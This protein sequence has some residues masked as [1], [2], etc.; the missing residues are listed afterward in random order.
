MNE[1]GMLSRNL[2]LGEL[3]YKLIVFIDVKALSEEACEED[4]LELEPFGDYGSKENETERRYEAEPKN[5][6]GKES[7]YP[8]KI[9]ICVVVFLFDKK[10]Y[11][12]GIYRDVY[13][14]EEEV[15]QKSE[16]NIREL[17]KLFLF[18]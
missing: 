1:C 16:V 8:H 3:Y 9:V 11:H 13:T 7:Y 10:S 18:I 12:D 6:R 17:D 14:K 15:A 4:F 5:L 2:C